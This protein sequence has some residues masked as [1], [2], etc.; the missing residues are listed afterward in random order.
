MK[1]NFVSFEPLV[2]MNRQDLQSGKIVTDVFNDYF[3]GDIKKYYKNFNNSSYKI[4]DIHFV[5]RLNL[6]IS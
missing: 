1:F 5:E 2:V 4:L 6:Q 3:N